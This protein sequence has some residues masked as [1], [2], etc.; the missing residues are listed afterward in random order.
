MCLD[1]CP[2]VWKVVVHVTCCEQLILV[3]GLLLKYLVL[4]RWVSKKQ[5][6][7]RKVAFGILV[8]GGPTEALVFICLVSLAV[9]NKYSEQPPLSLERS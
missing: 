3:C 9:D 7:F 4:F 8:T 6:Y 5:Y 2:I 1:Q